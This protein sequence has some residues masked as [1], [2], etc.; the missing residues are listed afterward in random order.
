M[1]QIGLPIA[2]CKHMNNGPL[3]L[4]IVHKPTAMPQRTDRDSDAK[5]IGP[6]QRRICIRRRTTDGNVI[7]LERRIDSRPS[8]AVVSRYR[9]SL[10]NAMP[11]L[12]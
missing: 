3:N 6:K 9:T 2:V 1:R 7:E 4:N 11:A 5:R 12:A 8:Q 10:P